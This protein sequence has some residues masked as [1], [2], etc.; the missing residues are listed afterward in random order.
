ME[1]LEG[2]WIFEVFAF[3]DTVPNM[4]L[5]LGLKLVKEGIFT[6]PLFSLS[7][8]SSEDYLFYKNLLQSCIFQMLHSHLRLCN[9]NSAPAI[10]ESPSLKVLDFAAVLCFTSACLLRVKVTELLQAS[11]QS[12][13]SASKR[14]SLALE[15]TR[16]LPV[17][18]Q[19]LSIEPASMQRFESVLFFL[20]FLA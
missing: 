14:P 18:S 11:A 13:L 10:G 7:L 8:T 15:I 2:G 4:S 12:S 1:F 20:V 6:C 3:G 17:D 16:E 9:L 5:G 19:A